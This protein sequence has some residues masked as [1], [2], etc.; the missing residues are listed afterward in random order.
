MLVKFKVQKLSRST[1]K[2]ESLIVLIYFALFSMLRN[3]HN[4]I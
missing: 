4:K 3:L 2:D 1:D